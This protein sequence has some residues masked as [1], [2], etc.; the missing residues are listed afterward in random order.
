MAKALSA[1]FHGWPI[2]LEKER[3]ELRRENAIW[4]TASALFHGVLDRH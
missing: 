4:R 3:A 2:V 1:G